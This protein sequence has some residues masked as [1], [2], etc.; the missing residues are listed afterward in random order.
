MDVA[1]TDIWSLVTQEFD[2]KLPR[3]T[4]VV[5]KSGRWDIAFAYPSDCGH[6]GYHLDCRENTTYREETVAAL[7]F[8]E[9][10]FGEEAYARFEKPIF[11][12]RGMRYRPDVVTRE[13]S[14]SSMGLEVAESFSQAPEGGFTWELD[15]VDTQHPNHPFNR[16]L[17]TLV[18]MA[19]PDCVVQRQGDLVTVHF[20]PQK[21]VSTPGSGSGKQS[22][23]LCLSTE[24][25]A[26]AQYENLEAFIAEAA[27]G[28]L[29]QGQG[30]GRYLVFQHRLR[31]DRDEHAMVRFGLSFRDGAGARAAN[32]PAA[33]E[34]IREDWNRWFASL[35]PLDSP[36]L[37]EQRAYYRCWTVNRLNC[38][39]HHRYGRAMLEA[40]PVYRGFWQWATNAHELAG[41]MNPELGPEVVRKVLSLFLDYQ[42]EDGYV[43]HAIYLDDVVPGEAWAKGSLVQ[44]PH[45]PWAALRYYR[46]SGDREALEKWYGPLEK[47]YRYLCSSRDEAFLN[48]HL[49]AVL[50]SYDT[51]LDTTA[52]FERVTYGEN[53]CREQYCYPA[54][55][56]A[57]RARFEQAMGRMAKITGLGDP[58]AWRKASTQTVAAMNEHLWDVE[59]GWYGARHEDG[60]LDTR[61]GVDGLFPFAYGLVDPERAQQARNNFERLV[62][63]YGVRT[64]AAGEP[65]Q[66]HNIYWRGPVWPKAV[67]MGAAT[68]VRYYPDLVDAVRRGAVAFALRYPSIWECMDADTGDIARGDGGMRATPMVSSNVGATELM[69]ALLMMRGVDVLAFD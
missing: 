46:A 63:P 27:G 42:R 44:T 21:Q 66:Y 22:A 10:T 41:D 55:F 65:G 12:F 1:N 62:A 31:L 64:M 52:I 29:G 33:L 26:M 57:E 28:A 4:S 11:F 14:F 69:G 5:V 61:V 39:E 54:I 2:E 49:W 17:F 36:D 30:R 58:A 37:D 16:A 7:S 47:Y 15:C 25:E 13:I 23:V 59:C 6:I 32:A 24:C 19:D 45:I 67:A 34:A 50:S 8:A 18:T 3:H 40:L 35:P 56:A 43:T 60:T 48:W 51:G 20:D 53:G 38:Y 9:Y 68:A